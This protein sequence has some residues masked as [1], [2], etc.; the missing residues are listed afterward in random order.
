[1]KRTKDFFRNLLC[2][3]RLRLR[4]QTYLSIRFRS[5]P[6]PRVARD[7]FEKSLMLQ[8]LAIVTFAAFAPAANAAK[9]IQA[10]PFVTH[11]QFA[12]SLYAE[13]FA[14]LASEFNE[15]ATRLRDATQTLCEQPNASLLREA[16]VAW[17][18]S[19]LAWERLNAVSLGPLIERRSAR[20]IDFQPTRPAMIEAAAQRSAQESPALDAIGAPAKGFPALEWLFWS[21]KRNPPVIAKS[22]YCAYGRALA[23][24]VVQEAQ[25]LHQ[26]FQVLAAKNWEEDQDA[27]R[28]TQVEFLNQAVAGL[29]QLRLKKMDKPARTQKASEFPRS[30]SDATVQAWR[31]QFD[32]IQDALLGKTESDSSSLDAFLRGRGL[33]SISATLQNSVAR[34]RSAFGPTLKP[35]PAATKRASKSIG[36]ITR[37]LQEDVAP[38][39]K[40]SIGF[41]DSDGD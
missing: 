16:R 38:A 34:A 3:A 31:A 21:D 33:L 35:T 36:A 28:E 19:M 32:S 4:R 13:H 18:N 24:S 40:I 8:T 39:I 12:R 23:G 15:A 11:A 5:S 9:A 22:A 6:Q 37:V 27:A 14:P 10:A 7:S 1:M 2:G 29:E 17:G 30:L 25:A 26:D 20:M 41:S